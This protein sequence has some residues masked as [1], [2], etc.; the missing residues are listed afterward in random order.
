MSL[1]SFAAVFWMSRNAP[2]KVEERSLG[3]A[4]R[5]F[6]MTAAKETKMSYAGF[7]FVLLLT[8]LLIGS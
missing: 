3:G 1:V 7:V 5:D 4:L 6:Q 2:P 8:T